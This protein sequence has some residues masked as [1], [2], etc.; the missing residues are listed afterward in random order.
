MPKPLAICIEDLGAGEE[1]RRY[2]RCV[3]VVG[4]RPGLRV[5]SAGAV[6]WKS[7]DAVACELWVSGDDK[8][9]LY[10]PAGAPGVVCRRAGRALDV[11][12]GKPVV[13]LDQDRFDV[14]EKRLRVHVH[15]TARVVHEP[16]FLAAPRATSGLPRAAAAAVALG[17]AL[18][19]ADCKKDKEEPS[20]AGPVADSAVGERPAT[21]AG[22]NTPV[23]DV[24]SDIEIRVAPPMV[25]APMEPPPPVGEDVGA[26][27]AGPDAIVDA[28]EIEVRE[29]PPKVAADPDPVEDAGMV[30]EDAGAVA[31]AAGEPDPQDAAA[32]EPEDAARRRETTIEVRERPPDMMMKE[33]E[34]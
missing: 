12:V 5:T 3:A 16:S 29:T 4:R 34:P 8:L 28:A 11:P 9:I 27:T 17:A 24:G 18:G 10:R 33:E 23:P 15:G 1:G 30:A 22:L 32:A 26:P 25:A 14:G 6:I 21:D 2:L 7:D 31:D 19:A 13:L 20:T